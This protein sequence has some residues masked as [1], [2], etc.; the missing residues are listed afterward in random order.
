MTIQLLVDNDTD[1]TEPSTNDDFLVDIKYMLDDL[2]AKAT[3]GNI[4]LDDIMVSADH[5]IRPKG[6]DAFHLSK[7]EESN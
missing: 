1:T 5:A 4:Y 7:S 6:I 3:K 2:C